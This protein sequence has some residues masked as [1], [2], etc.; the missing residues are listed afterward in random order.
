MTGSNI[1]RT[2]PT[3]TFASRSCA[4]RAANR[5][6]SRASVPSE[7]TST[8]ASKLSCAMSATSARSCC[9]WIAAGDIRRWN[10]RLATTAS[11]RTTSAASASHTSVRNSSTAATTS[12]TDDAER[13][14]QR[15]EDRVAASTSALAFD[16]S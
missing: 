2:M 7:V 13:E 11:G 4:A 3:R 1:A 15:V 5:A 14:G 6:S 10:T 16:S 12:M 9:A 8:A